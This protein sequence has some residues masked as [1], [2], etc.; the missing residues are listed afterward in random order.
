MRISDILPGRETHA[1]ALLRVTAVHGTRWPVQE[2]N[3][4]PFW[5]VTL[6]ST[7]KG[8]LYSGGGSPNIVSR[9]EKWATGV[10]STQN[11]G[12]FSSRGKRL[13][14]GVRVS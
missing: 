13:S 8:H 11:G 5:K 14:A 3:N 2:P 7:S 6:A 4:G 12:Y 1:N 9:L 10:G